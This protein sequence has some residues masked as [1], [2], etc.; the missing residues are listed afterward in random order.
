M[1][2]I[3]KSD[4]KERDVIANKLQDAQAELEKAIDEY[5]SLMR[6]A[7]EKVDVCLNTM[8]ELIY[9]ANQWRD[10]IVTDIQDYMDER[11][12]KW[13]ESDKAREMESW[14][15]AYEE[16]FPELELE[17]PDEISLD[18]EDYAQLMWDLPE[19]FNG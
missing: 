1:T 10:S 2:T 13:H 12:E 4:I 8:N 15:A 7:W 9:D 16:E 18:C 11:S 19:D 17:C 6:S 14:K 5:N 3:S